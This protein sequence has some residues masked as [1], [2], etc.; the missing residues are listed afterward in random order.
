[1]P[2]LLSAGLMSSAPCFQARCCLHPALQSSRLDL[3]QSPASHL[4]CTWLRPSPGQEAAGVMEGCP[5]L[6]LAPMLCLPEIGSTRH[7]A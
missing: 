3:L 1:M 6:L 4:L 7:E 5:H 2:E